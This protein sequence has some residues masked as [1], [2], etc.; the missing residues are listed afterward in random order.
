MSPTKSFLWILPQSLRFPY[1][2]SL[3]QTAAKSKIFMRTLFGNCHLEAFQ[4][5]LFQ[6]DLGLFHSNSGIQ[7]ELTKKLYNQKKVVKMNCC[8]RNDN[9]FYTFQSFAI[10]AIWCLYN[11][12]SNRAFMNFFFSASYVR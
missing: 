12:F 4:S 5:I 3:I 10:C 1:L 7:L 8:R 2:F 11:N 9:I 6:I